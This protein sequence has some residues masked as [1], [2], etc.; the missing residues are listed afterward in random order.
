MRLAA[1]YGQML[2]CLPLGPEGI[3]DQP[4][5]RLETARRIVAMAAEE[6]LAA[7]DLMLDP[8]TL[9][10]GTG[11]T[12]TPEQAQAVHAVLRAQLRA[13]ASSDRRVRILYGGSMNAGN[14][15][16]LLSQPDIDGGLIG[17]ASLKADEFL[18]IIASCPLATA[19]L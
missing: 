17:G 3:P 6:G 4:E 12:A 5:T 19:V 15:A 14:A 8:L 7:G 1:R 11:R 10:I 2:V 9:T 13:A 18:S 16:E